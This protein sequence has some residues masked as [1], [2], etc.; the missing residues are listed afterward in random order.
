MFML[1]MLTDIIQFLQ[2]HPKPFLTLHILGVIVGMG[3]ATIADILFFN[4]LKDFRI[5]KK[6]AEVMQLLSHIITAALLLMY[7]SGTALYLSDMPRF[8]ASAPF[9]SKLLIII[10]V[11]INGILMHKYISPHMVHLSFLQ[12]T[13]H[14]DHMIH[15]LRSMAFA[16]GAVSFV[17]WYSIF[18]IAMLKSYIPKQTS[19]IQIMGSYALILFAAIVVS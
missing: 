16:M 6:E 12:R 8:N 15:R 4:F 9:V 5:S 3:G 10:V 11:T 19:S 17:S 13:F 7:L 1:S 14:P 18:F 2:A